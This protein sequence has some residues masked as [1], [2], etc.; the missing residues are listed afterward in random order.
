MQRTFG[1][2][3]FIGCVASCALGQVTK[4]GSGYLL[5][6]KYHAGQIVKYSVTT[7]ILGVTPKP[8]VIQLPMTIKC[9]GVKNG[10]AHLK[11]TTGPIYDGKT[12]QKGTTKVQEVYLDSMG[13]PAEG[14]SPSTMMGSLPLKPVKVGE[15]WT[16]KMP[17]GNL[18]GDAVAYFVFRGVKTVKSKKVAVISIVLSSVAKG[19]KVDGKGELDILAADGIMNLMDL[20]ATMK[21]DAKAPGGQGASFITNTRMVRQ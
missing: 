11:M 7:T 6:M 16:S 18:P 8:T 4:S 2:L 1:I 21:M 19:L 9:L 10:I 15:K 20:N 3:I 13:R 12:P 17:L 14:G 5:R